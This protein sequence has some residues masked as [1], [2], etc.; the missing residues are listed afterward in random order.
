MRKSSPLRSLSSQ[1]LS[2]SSFLL[3]FL[4]YPSI[5]V[6]ALLP[7]W[8]FPFLVFSNWPSRPGKLI[9]G[10]SVADFPPHFRLFLPS[11]NDLGSA[12]GV[13]GPTPRSQHTGS[14]STASALLAC[15]SISTAPTLD[16][17]AIS[18]PAKKIKKSRPFDQNVR[19]KTLS[20]KR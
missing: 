19:P 8:F 2:S 3:R 13:L 17:R 1:S 6:T 10:W 18:S 5:W 14:S 9:V 12:V 15:Y 20:E 4:I 11:S 7:F 16:S